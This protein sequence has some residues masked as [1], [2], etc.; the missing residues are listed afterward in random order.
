MHASSFC[1]HHL[2][3]W[4]KQWTSKFQRQTVLT[5]LMDDVILEWMLLPVNSQRVLLFIFLSNTLFAAR[6][7]PS[8]WGLFFSLLLLLMPPLK[9][10]SLRNSAKGW[11]CFSR[12][13]DIIIHVLRYIYIHIIII[14][15]RFSI[16]H[17]S[18][19]FKTAHKQE[20]FT[21]I[22]CRSHRL[23]PYTT[24]SSLHF[25]ACATKFL[26]LF[27]DTWFSLQEQR[28]FRMSHSGLHQLQRILPH[29]SL[30][31]LP[32]M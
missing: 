31:H 23:L 13:R 1:C 4:Y 24:L 14:W 7:I 29:S 26:H 10:P 15:Q 6:F 27:Y 28:F 22:R 16:F 18:F 20:N 17:F 32:H 21:L 11:Y 30:Y 8:H 2:F 12:I 9:Q 25:T 3:I 19:N 5:A